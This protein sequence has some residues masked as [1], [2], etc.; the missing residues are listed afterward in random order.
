MELAA[1]AARG[2]EVSVAPCGWAQFN[3]N[4][5]VYVRCY[6]ETE[7]G[8]ADRYDDDGFIAATILR[9]PFFVRMECCSSRLCLRDTVESRSL[10]T[11]TS[12]ELCEFLFGSGRSERHIQKVEYSMVSSDESL[13]LMDAMGFS[14][15]EHLTPSKSVVLLAFRW[16]GC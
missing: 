4:V 11:R 5:H 1:A 12:E 16:H 13:L 15:V 2:C 6:H 9:A 14:G 3:P 7:N 8:V 10:C